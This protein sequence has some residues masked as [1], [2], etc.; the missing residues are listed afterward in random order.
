VR[1]IRIAA[2]VA[3]LAL[4]GSAMAAPVSA[5]KETKSSGATGFYTINDD[6]FSPGAACRYENNP[7]KKRD[8]T[9]KV[10][11]RKIFT[12]G[13]WAQMSWVGHRVI[14]QQRRNA[15]KP[16]KVRWSS[17]VRKGR[18]NDTEVVF[19]GPRSFKTPENHRM[20]YRVVHKLIYYQKGSKTKQAG[21]V[22]GNVEVYKHTGT[23]GPAPYLTG[24]EG[25]PG[26]WCNKRFWPV[27]T[28]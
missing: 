12:H 22:R 5:F 8:E 20:Q 13:P 16:W 2:T 17:S 23:Q 24:Q 15:S 11:S 18:A 7:G 1:P 14:V 25:G 21:M 28:P 19:F 27:P 9:N 10:Q 26:G 6:A 3:A 4:V